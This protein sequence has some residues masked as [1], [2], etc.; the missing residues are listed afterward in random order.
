MK[1]LILSCV[2]I[3]LGHVAWTSHVYARDEVNRDW[4]TQN[5]ASMPLAFTKNTGQWDERAL[6]RADA[7]AA[8]VW[9]TTEGAYYQFARRI[10]SDGSPPSAKG[11][12]GYP[13]SG[14]QTPALDFDRGSSSAL[15]ELNEPDSLETIVLKAAL[16]GANPNPAVSGDDLMDYRCNYFLGNDP[17]G[18]RTDVPNYQAVVL[19]EVYPGIDLAYYGNGRQMEYDFRVSAGADYSQIRIQYEGAEGLAIA[20]DGALIVTTKWGEIKELAPVVYQTVGGGRRPVTARYEVQADHSLGFRLGP[21]LDPA[22]PV[23]IDPV[24]VYS[25]YLGGSFNDAS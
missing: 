4:I 8:T 12:V 18:W 10:R 20:D 2:V 15:N 23:V 25:T 16:V 11:G 22:L 17:S 21:E 9:I 5:L 6:F 24:L 3:L 13:D 19:E 1:K 7:G 14:R